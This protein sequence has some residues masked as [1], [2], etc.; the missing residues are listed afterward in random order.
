[1]LIRDQDRLPTV[2]VKNVNKNPR[3]ATRAA[4]ATAIHNLLGS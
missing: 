1:V 4:T 3:E 2:H